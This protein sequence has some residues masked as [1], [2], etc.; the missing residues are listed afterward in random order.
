M[1]AEMAGLKGHERVGTSPKAQGFQ[2]LS[3]VVEGGKR[4]GEWI[5][6]RWSD[7]TEHFLGVLMAPGGSKKRV[8]WHRQWGAFRPLGPYTGRPRSRGILVQRD[9]CL[10]NQV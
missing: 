2:D 5:W 4:S 7:P 6:S 9:S 1:A 3:K 8:A 10:E